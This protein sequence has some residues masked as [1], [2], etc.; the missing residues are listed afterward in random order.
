[1]ASTAHK[2]KEE[3][4]EHFDSESVLNEKVDEL[5]SLIKKS[6]HFVTF[7]GAGISTSTGYV[8]LFFFNSLF[9]ISRFR[10]SCLCF[11]LNLYQFLIVFLF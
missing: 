3:L 2:T 7:T 10:R 9:F 1:M 8:F 4:E 5:V 6:K 11:W